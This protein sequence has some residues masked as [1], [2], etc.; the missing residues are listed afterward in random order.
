MKVKWGGADIF[1]CYHSIARNTW[2]TISRFTY[3]FKSHR[4]I[5]AVTGRLVRG[6]ST[7]DTYLSQLL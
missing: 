5:L 2:L 7:L 6:S 1:K 3:I 4:G